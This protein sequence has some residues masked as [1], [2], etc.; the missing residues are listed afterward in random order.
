[1]SR[2][3]ENKEMIKTIEK[4]DFQGTIEECN[5]K[6]N[7][8]NGIVLK[9]ISKSLAVIADLLTEINYKVQISWGSR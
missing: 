2:I 7:L 6:T 8:N 1:M 9:D 5:L 3:E 4:K